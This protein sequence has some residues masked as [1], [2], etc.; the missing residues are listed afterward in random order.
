MLKQGTVTQLRKGELSRKDG[1][2]AIT[3]RFY[4]RGLKR[5]L[6]D[7]YIRDLSPD[8][9]LFKEFKKFQKTIGHEAAFKKVNY[10]KRFHLSFDGYEKLRQ[11]SELS[12]RQDVYLICQCEIGQ[13]CHREIMLLIAHHQ[14]GAK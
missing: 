14:F 7:E 2:I 4:P 12:R 1:F 11:L 13:Y 8:T 10:E 5:E 6:R 3:M 9:N